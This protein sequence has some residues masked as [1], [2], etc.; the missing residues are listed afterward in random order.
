ME[1]ALERN[2]ADR[3]RNGFNRLAVGEAICFISTPSAGL[4]TTRAKLN[5]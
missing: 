1:D 4:R 2:P 5:L 3:Q